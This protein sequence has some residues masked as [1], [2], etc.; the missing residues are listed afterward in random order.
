MEQI[1]GIVDV[2]LFYSEDNGYSVFK[3]EDGTAVVGNLPKLNSG[4]EVEI[5][6]S[7][8]THPK[9]GIQ[10]K[11]ESLDVNYPTTESGIT[12]YLASGLIKGIGKVTAERIVRK[13]GEAA[14]TIFDENINRLLEIE[15]I[16]RKKLE[17]IKIGW[18]EQKGI[19]NVMLFL[20]T[21]GISTAYSLKIYKTYGDQ[22]PEVIKRNPYRLMSDVW[23]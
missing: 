13:F 12:R 7:W 21:H 4:D 20:Q 18:E 15:G 9:Y 6:G 19:K 17:T 22:A 5:T 14:L 8:I 10:F 16:G 2:Y 1:T 23:V 3:L 11:V